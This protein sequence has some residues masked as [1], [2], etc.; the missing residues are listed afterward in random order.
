LRLEPIM[1]EQQNTELV[2]QAYAA[3]G[4]GA[5]DD[6]L[7]C[8][9]ADIDWEIPAVPA[10]A[11][12]GKRQG[13]DQVAQYFQLAAEQ[14]AVREFTPREFIAGGDKVVVLG[15]GAW[16]ARETGQDFESDWVHVFTVKD[17]RIVAF[18]EFMDAHVAVEAFQCFPLGSKAA[19]SATH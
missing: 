9:A 12:T 14:Q 18:R 11:F 3:Y 2:Q 5:V 16:T 7:A 8:M 1:N 19:A 13:R 6:V 4:R 10:L 17:G 15:H